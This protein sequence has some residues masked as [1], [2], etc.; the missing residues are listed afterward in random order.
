[1]G[2]AHMGVG[3]VSGGIRILLGVSNIFPALFGPSKGVVLGTKMGGV[4]EATGVPGTLTPHTLW[5]RG[6]VEWVRD[7]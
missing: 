6:C 5:S 3:S 7:S 2:N 4:E 1:M